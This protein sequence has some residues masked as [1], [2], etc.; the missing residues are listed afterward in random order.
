MAIKIGVIWA[1]SKHR[2]KR[3]A[4]EFPFSSLDVLHPLK[5][6]RIL[7]KLQRQKVRFA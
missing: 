6:L 3:S 4:L 5:E 2:D 7:L 1:C